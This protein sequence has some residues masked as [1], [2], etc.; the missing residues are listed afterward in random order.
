VRELS[1]LLEEALDYAGNTHSLRDVYDQ[2][3]AG[4]A[5][6][7]TEEGAVLVTEVVDTPQKRVL[8]FWLAAGEL[9]SC[10]GLHRRVLEWGRAQG[11]EMATFTGRR[12]WERV[13]GA[14]GWSPALTVM[15]REV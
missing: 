5:Q 10:L 11:C 13:L 7:W 3:M 4:A 12:G 8:R 1:R 9:E 14:E 2:I 15:T 6:L